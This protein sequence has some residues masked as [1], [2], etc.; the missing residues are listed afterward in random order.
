MSKIIINKTSFDE[1]MLGDISSP[2]WQRID[3]LAKQTG[4]YEEI[5]H[6]MNQS[7]KYNKPYI[8]LTDEEKNS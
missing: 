8:E 6:I 5:N 7:K 2:F 4:Y 3:Q 1:V